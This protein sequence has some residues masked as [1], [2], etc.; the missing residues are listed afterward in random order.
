MFRLP[1]LFKI[2][3]GLQYWISGDIMAAGL[4]VLVW[5]LGILFVNHFIACSWFA[6]GTADDGIPSWVDTVRKFYKEHTE[7]EASEWYM[8][9][10]SLH[11][12][13]TQFTP[14]SMEVVPVNVYER[15]FTVITI[16]GALVAFSSFLSSITNEVASL[17]LKR[18]DHTN[19]Q[20]QLVR[21]LSQN[22]VSLEL[23]GRL[24]ELAQLQ[25][26]E[27][28]R[29]RRVHEKDV[30]LL[31]Q[32]PSSL[33]DQLRLEVYGPILRDHPLTRTMGI[34]CVSAFSRICSSALSQQSLLPN[35]ELFAFGDEAQCMY[36]VVAGKMVYHHG[37]YLATEVV[38][39]KP[40]HIFEA[41][42]SLCEQVLVFE[43]RHQGLL[44]ARML[45]EFVQLD[46]AVFRD[47]VKAHVDLTAFFRS[48]GK[49]CVETLAK[50]ERRLT[51]QNVENQLTCCLISEVL[52]KRGY[53][54]E[55][56]SDDADTWTWLHR[57]TSS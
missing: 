44:T 11:W 38:K 49:H 18:R 35:E 12:S 56:E 37:R 42:E 57:L 2:I 31:Q 10:T 9:T 34:L 28:S 13:L 32:M 47:T 46:A 55:S 1:K 22:R 29:V 45:C 52:Y 3:N 26:V 5:I 16:F 17:R 14:A 25:Q 6:L 27:S 41:E 20:A 43:W 15:V 19:N 40:S 50:E 54:F 21:F 4:K 8:Y 51:D 33:K 36:F 30:I 23:G 53:T 48:F 24:Q 39:L 7:Y